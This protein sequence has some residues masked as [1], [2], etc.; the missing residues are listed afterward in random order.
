MVGGWL[1]STWQS[2]YLSGGSFQCLS[3]E[4]I[5]FVI[6]RKAWKPTCRGV[7]GINSLRNWLT[8]SWQLSGEDDDTVTSVPFH[9]FA[10]KDPS[11][12][13]HPHL[14]H[15]SLVFIFIYKVLRLVLILCSLVNC[16]DCRLFICLVLVC[17][18]AGQISFPHTGTKRSLVNLRHPTVLYT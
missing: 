14:R 12:L 9:A 11:T 3:E 7:P 2:F 6:S 13:S 8:Y 10:P 17:F 18:A 4:H 16:L 1:S 5:S 15:H